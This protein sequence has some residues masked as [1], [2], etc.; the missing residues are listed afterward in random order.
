MSKRT[1]ELVKA[2]SSKKTKKQPKNQ[3][4][5][6]FAKRELWEGRPVHWLAIGLA[7]VAIA[8]ASYELAK[9]YVAIPEFNGII[10]FVSTFVI[11]SRAF[12]K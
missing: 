8:F 2:I 1:D 3:A 9:Y 12:K 5:K 7:Y 10:A 4:I 11:G 6:A